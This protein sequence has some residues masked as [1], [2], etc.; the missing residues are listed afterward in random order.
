VPGGEYLFELGFGVGTSLR[1]TF[2]CHTFFAQ[3]RFPADFVSSFFSS[4][5]FVGCCLPLS[6][7]TIL[8][9]F[10]AHQAARK[11]LQSLL[12]ER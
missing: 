1:T 3:M 10:L 4:D 9:I 2:Q 11:S 5:E 12:A 6:S 8:C 7:D